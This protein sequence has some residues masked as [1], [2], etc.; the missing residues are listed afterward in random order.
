M[1]KKG[2]NMMGMAEVVSLR[3][4]QLYK[5]IQLIYKD[6]ENY[7]VET[8]KSYKTYVREFFQIVKGKEL[9]F[10]NENDIKIK[11]QDVIRFRNILKE[12]KINNKTINKK[13]YA[14]KKLLS[15]LKVL[16]YDDINLEFFKE[17]KKL[18]E[19]TNSYG[20]LTVDEVLLMANL[21][22]TKERSLKK[23]K[24]LFI[25]FAL[26]TCV[27]KSAIL[28]LT[29]KDFEDQ[30]N[31]EVY[32]KGLD[33]GD[34]EYRHRIKKEFF[35]ELLTLKVD[36][37]DKVFNVSKSTI[38]EMI[39][40]LIKL[41]N[42]PPERNI[43]FHSIRKAGITFQY[44]VTGDIK[45]AQKAAN[46][47]DPSLTLKTYVE[48]IDYGNYGAYSSQNDVDEDILDNLSLEQ[49]KELKDKVNKDLQL[50]LK[51]KAKELFSNQNC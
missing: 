6:L 24:S 48:S 9:E 18:P 14:V 41:M 46:H 3:D 22:M 47:S 28:N 2:M 23:A 30:E 20:T 45:A 21:A 13:V 7:N 43:V 27:R 34:K 35:N 42:I 40:R 19:K 5:D 10:L 11:L 44:R 25:L 15:S 39:P 33:K 51:L 8:A 32:I 31:G 50:L 4:N 49:W 37:I 26:D 17:I 12:S 29:W 38:D 16:E 36:G 1:G